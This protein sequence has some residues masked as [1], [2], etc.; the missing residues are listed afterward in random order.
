MEARSD[1]RH[2]PRVLF[3]SLRSVSQDTPVSAGTKCTLDRGTGTDAGL[4]GRGR[5]RS[6]ALYEYLHIDQKLALLPAMLNQALY[7]HGYTKLI[8]EKL[9]GVPT[10]CMDQELAAVQGRMLNADYEEVGCFLGLLESLGQIERATHFAR[11]LSTVED[12]DV[13]DTAK[14]FLERRQ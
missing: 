3:A 6:I 7:S 10:E 8:W 12:E 2:S 11:Q 13:M 5:R 9:K 1:P 4:A 14:A